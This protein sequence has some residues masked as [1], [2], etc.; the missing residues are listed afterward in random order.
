MS[1]N[2]MNYYNSIRK[3]FMTHSVDFDV[4]YTACKVWSNKYF[5]LLFDDNALKEL[6]HDD[7]FKIICAIHDHIKTIAPYLVLNFLL[8]EAHHGNHEFLIP[9]AYIERVERPE[10]G[11]IELESIGCANNLYSKILAI[12]KE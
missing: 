3:E 7:N 2:N 5:K 8:A 10:F 4:M 12:L 6:V 1:D 11:F 9:L